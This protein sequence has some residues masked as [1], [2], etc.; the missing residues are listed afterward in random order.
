M[1]DARISTK[2]LAR[3]DQ[4]GFTLRDMLV[5]AVLIGRPGICGQDVQHDMEFLNRSAV[6]GNL[7]RLIRRG[8]VED[9]RTQIKQAVPSIYWPTEDGVSL[10]QE[11]T[12]HD[13]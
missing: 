10:W 9:R 13:L 7:N 3:L 8:L 5:L 1:I 11:L 6:V 4:E 2:V 12:G